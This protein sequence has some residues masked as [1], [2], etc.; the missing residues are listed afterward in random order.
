M[1]VNEDRIKELANALA[2]AMFARDVERLQSIYDSMSEE[3]GAA[4]TPHWA[5]AALELVGD[6]LDRIDKVIAA[7]TTAMRTEGGDD[8][9][10]ALE[11]ILRSLPEADREVLVRS[12][13]SR[14]VQLEDH[15]SAQVDELVSELDSNSSSL[16]SADGPLMFQTTEEL[17]RVVRLSGRLALDDALFAVRPMSDEDREAKEEELAD[18]LSA[19]GQRAADRDMTRNF[20]ALTLETKWTPRLGRKTHAALVPVDFPTDDI[21]TTYRALC[22]GGKGVCGLFW[23]SLN[24]VDCEGC[25]N[26]LAIGGF[27]GPE[28]GSRRGTS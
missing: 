14:V 22:G 24:S 10:D 26:V 11:S 28:P 1:A 9:S 6:Q 17:E 5:E 21:G 19:A 15:A 20:K 2:A 13:V 8:D 7:L 23:E 12:L 3:E 4:V 16:L 18:Q 27:L 25:R